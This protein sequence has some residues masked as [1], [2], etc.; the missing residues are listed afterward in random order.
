MVQVVRLPIPRCSE[1][2]LKWAFLYPGKISFLQISKGM[3]TWYSIRAN[4]FGFLARKENNDIV[5]AV[6]PATIQKDVASVRPGGVLFYSDD[7]LLSNERQDIVKYA[8][9][10][11]SLVNEADVPAKIR[12]YVKNMIYVGVLGRML[13]IDMDCIREALD[14]HFMGNE[15]AMNLNMRVVNLAYDWAEKNLEKEDPFLVQKMNATEGCIM[16]DGNT[17][18]AL[19]SIYGGVQFSAWYPI[20]PATGLPEALNQVLP[21]NS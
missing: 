21:E 8:M 20:T 19:G 6:N 3:P 12:N 13:Q 9:P 11:R 7:L 18:G 16:G 15:K 10:I 1:R 17:S 4:K 14:F 2:Y 5:V